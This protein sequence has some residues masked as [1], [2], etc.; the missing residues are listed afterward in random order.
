LDCFKSSSVQRPM[1]MNHSI[2]NVEIGLLLMQLHT[3]TKRGSVQPKSKDFY[4]RRID[5]MTFS[6]QQSTLIIRARVPASVSILP[7]ECF[8]GMEQSHS[9]SFRRDS[10]LTQIESLAFSSSSLRSIL[11]ACSVQILGPC[12]FFTLR[13]TFINFIRIAITLEAN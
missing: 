13:I 6:G 5:V 7:G 11:I 9:I 4:H 1:T 2:V 3:R 12:C 8:N 10:S